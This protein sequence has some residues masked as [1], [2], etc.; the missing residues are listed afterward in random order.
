MKY[1]IELVVLRLLGQIQI[2]GQ[3]GVPAIVEI[4]RTSVSR[5]YFRPP[6]HAPYKLSSPV[7]T[8]MASIV[9]IMQFLQDAS[10]EFSMSGSNA[11]AQ[12]HVPL[13]G[14]PAHPH[15]NSAQLASQMTSKGL[16]RSGLLRR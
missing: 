14:A 11:R 12:E 4:E 13:R 3:P 8:T 10:L 2:S 15:D 16:F 1:W 9:G 6:I 5:E 7:V